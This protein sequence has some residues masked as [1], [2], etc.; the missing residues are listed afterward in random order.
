MNDLERETAGPG[1]EPERTIAQSIDEIIAEVKT[2]PIPPPDL[3]D[4]DEWEK[5]IESGRV[6]DK[7]RAQ[8]IGLAI[9][10]LRDL[11]RD[12]VGRAEEEIG[13]AKSREQELG[14][15]I[16]AH[17]AAIYEYMARYYEDLMGRSADQK[18][19]KEF[20]RVTAEAR[21]C[22]RIFQWKERIA[23]L[24]GAKMVEFRIRPQSLH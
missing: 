21:R 2:N 5:E 9:K 17:Q 22:G 10:D 3:S 19:D 13:Q 11:S 12:F 20:A 24:L 14:A 6:E 8:I 23:R 7:D 16:S 1:Q 18:K 4:I 15:R